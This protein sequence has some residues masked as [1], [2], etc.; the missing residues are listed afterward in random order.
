MN[1]AA[2]SGRLFFETDFGR[3]SISWTQRGLTHLGL[4][5]SGRART[6]RGLPK[7]PSPAPK[8][9]PPAWVRKAARQIASHLD[10]R[11]RD[12]S[13]IPLDLTGRPPF[14]RRVYQALQRVGPGLTVSYGEL[15]RMAGSPAAAR[16]VGQALARNPLGIVVPCHRVIA[17][18]GGA[19]GFSA[20]GGLRTKARLLAIE[21]IVLGIPRPK[22]QAAPRKSS[23]P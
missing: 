16:A 8:S 10:G 17:S 18:G 23:L 14:H 22:A 19:G 7:R 12:L 5:V 13:W 9:T 2:E 21:G 15:A 1:S 11:T 6:V 3:C 20:P 4:S